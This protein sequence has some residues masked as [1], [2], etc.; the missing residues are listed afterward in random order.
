M[1]HIRQNLVPHPKNKCEGLAVSTTIEGSYE[2]LSLQFSLQDPQQLVI[3]PAQV[4]GQRSQ[5]L[6]Q[7]TC[8]ELFARHID[9]NDYCEWNF[10]PGHSWGFFDHS[11][12]RVQRLPNNFSA[13]SAAPQSSSRGAIKSVAAQIN[14]TQALPA[15]Q[16]GAPVQI[17]LSAVLATA[18]GLEY[19][20]LTHV[21]SQKAD[22]HQFA[23]WLLR[24]P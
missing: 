16:Q 12:P 9:H 6:W 18:Q 13:L 19:F 1:I 21:N 14:L 10:S 2:R 15:L 22:F 20:A 8:F 4:D 24:L 3:W 17:G 23:S 7:S 5:T 11:A